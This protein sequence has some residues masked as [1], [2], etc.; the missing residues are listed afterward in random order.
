MAGLPTQAWPHALAQH[1]VVPIAVLDQTDCALRLGRTLTE[2]GLPLIEV[3]LRTAV[4]ID[5][6]RNLRAAC[7]DLLVGAG[8]VL[9]VAQAAAA[10]AAGAQFLVA[11]GYSAAV[12]A[13]AAAAG[14]PM[15]PGVLTP[16]EAQRAFAAGVRTVKVYPVGAV[17][18][19]SYLRALGS[20][21]PQMRCVPSGGI[22]AANLAEYLAQ[23]N[24]AAC[25]GSWLVDR[26]LL[27]AGRFDEIGRRVRQ[28][29]E[30]VQ[31]ARSMAVAS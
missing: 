15:L 8:T 5:S 29:V 22:D 2:A 7:P 18:G 19:A 16:T 4:A 20:V 28:A 3:T 9:D 27:A 1:G 26:A 11:P 25:G 14:V 30:I 21:L 24:V 23:P 31:R 6:I 12:V 13:W 10:H 17:G